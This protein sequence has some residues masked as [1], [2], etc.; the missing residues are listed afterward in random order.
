VLFEVA[1]VA[2][3]RECAEVVRSV[4][5]NVERCLKVRYVV[6]VERVCVQN[7]SDYILRIIEL[8][9]FSNKSQQPYSSPHSN[10]AFVIR[11]NQQRDF[12]AT[13]N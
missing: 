5:S 12:G 7:N 13:S 10:N 8:L 3:I 1:S 2:K 6:T 4:M 11:V 9:L